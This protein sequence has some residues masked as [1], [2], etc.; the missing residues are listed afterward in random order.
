MSK[1]ITLTQKEDITPK[2]PHCE[3]ELD[4]IFY[5]SKGF[6]FKRD[7]MYF[8]PSCLKTLGFAQS[9]IA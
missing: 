5:K 4:E 9:R 3:K 8:C 2:C 6:I 7:L 1:K